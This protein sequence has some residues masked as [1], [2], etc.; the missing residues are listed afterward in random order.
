MEENQVDKK[1]N[2]VKYA[3]Q[4]ADKHNRNKAELEDYVLMR[5]QNDR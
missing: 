5:E 2:V 3:D 4:G 1:N